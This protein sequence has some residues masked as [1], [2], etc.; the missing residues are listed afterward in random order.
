MGKI[1]QI[2]HERAGAGAFQLRIF[3]LRPSMEKHEFADA[4]A[5]DGTD[6]AEIEHHFTAVLQELRPPDATAQ[7]PRRDKRCGPGSERSPH[8]RDVEFP[9]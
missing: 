8:R 6:A 7:Q 2:A 4:S 5:I 9:N 1:K 3:R